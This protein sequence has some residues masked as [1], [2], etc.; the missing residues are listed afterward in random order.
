M[1]QL[2]E[3]SFLAKSLICDFSQM[4]LFLMY[5]Q[6]QDFTLQD[7]QNLWDLGFKNTDKPPNSPVPQSDS[8][9][10]FKPEL[11]VELAMGGCT[12]KIFL[13]QSQEW[14]IVSSFKVSIYRTR[15]SVFKLVHLMS[16][17]NVK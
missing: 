16:T 13:D 5:H 1:N 8:D 6:I 11:W 4:D 7:D 9:W 2:N 3:F 12:I 17:E 15:P 10:I 14:G